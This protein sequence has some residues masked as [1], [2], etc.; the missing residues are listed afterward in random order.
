M[1]RKGQVT[2][3]AEI[4]RELGLKQGD[5]VAFVL[6]RNEARLRRGDSV[7]ERTAGALRGYA[8][9]VLSAEELREVAEIVI[10]EDVVRRGRVNDDSTS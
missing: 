10:A 8:H 6:G 3:P 5:V 1:T 2:V 4:R 7:V 9:R